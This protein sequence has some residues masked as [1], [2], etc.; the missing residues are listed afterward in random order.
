MPS[1]PYNYEPLGPAEFRLLRLLPRPREKDTRKGGGEKGAAKTKRGKGG[2]KGRKWRAKEGR[3]IKSLEN[4]ELISV[5]LKTFPIS[6]SPSYQALS[7]CWGPPEPKQ[8]IRLNKTCQL[9]IWPELHTALRTFRDLDGT[10]HPQWIWIDQICINQEDEDEKGVQIGMMGDIYRQADIVTIWAGEGDDKMEESLEMMRRFAFAIGGCPSSRTMGFTVL[11]MFPEYLESYKALFERPWFTRT[12][13]LQEVL[14]SRSAQLVCGR[15][16]KGWSELSTIYLRCLEA[17]QSSL[18]VAMR[19]SLGYGALKPFDSLT[20]CHERNDRRRYD[21]EALT[22]VRQR[23]CTEPRDKVYGVLGL[24]SPEIRMQ[25]TVDTTL[26]YHTVF[27]NFAK[28]FLQHHGPDLFIL[29]PG[30]FDAEQQSESGSPTDTDRPSW[31]PDLTLPPL[32]THTWS[33][34]K[35]GRNFSGAAPEHPLFDDDEDSIIKVAGV[36]MATIKQVYPSL[37]IEALLPQLDADHVLMR[38]LGMEGPY[39]NPAAS[40]TARQEIRNFIRRAHSHFGYGGSSTG[41]A[42]FIRTLMGGHLYP[43]WLG[44]NFNPQEEFAQLLTALENE[45]RD[46]LDNG[47][48]NVFMTSMAEAWKGACLVTIAVPGHDGVSAGI[49]PMTSKKGDGIF[50]FFGGSTPVVMRDFGKGGKKSYK[51]VGPAYVDEF[52]DGTAF[53]GRNPLENHEKVTIR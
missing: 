51:V 47:P 39:F 41:H 25:I 28:A 33:R 4:S 49:A 27:K 9:E 12:W 24:I 18:G 17:C 52:M 40:A 7:Y 31:V 16:I 42:G 11:A 29:V 43:E 1:S 19:A 50:I 35:A 44:E 5:K 15:S 37:D 22:L 3:K 45:S 8:K 14:L 6:K 26:D 13:T 53:E 30:R 48:V 38:R 34:H 20:R 36:H 46:V 10:R 2:K 23:G 32:M 21:L